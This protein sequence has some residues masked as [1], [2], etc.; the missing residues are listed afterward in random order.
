M[1]KIIKVPDESTFTEADLKPGLRVIRKSDGAECFVTHDNDADSAPCWFVLQGHNM[2]LTPQC[3]YAAAIISDDMLDWLNR[4]FR[5]VESQPQYKTV[6]EVPVNWM[7]D[8]ELYPM[9]VRI[10]APVGSSEIHCLFTDKPSRGWYTSTLVSHA[11]VTRVHGPLT[12]DP[13][14][15]EGV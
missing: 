7:F 12:I 13:L 2:L 1:L 5:R 4:D 8:T 9:T 10:A 3:S 6:G 14:V 11:R 15:T